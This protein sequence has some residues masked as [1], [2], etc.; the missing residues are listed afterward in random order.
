MPHVEGFASFVVAHIVQLGKT[1]VIKHSGGVTAYFRSHFNPNLSHWKEKNH[2]S[3][4]WL[5]VSRGVAP[6][7]FVYVVYVALVGSKHE[8]KS[9]FQNMAAYIVKVQ[10]LKS[11]VLFG[12]DFNVRIVALLDTID[13]NNLFKLL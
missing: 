12:G 8:S 1:K 13:T 9:L 7:L 2:D 11:I 10:I 5:R 4:L 6:N 3:Y